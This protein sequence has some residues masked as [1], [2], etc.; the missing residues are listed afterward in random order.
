[1]RAPRAALATTLSRIDGLL[2]DLGR[3]RGDVLDIG[4]LHR[5]TGVPPDVITGLLR[6]EEVAEEP[7]G[8]RVRHRIRHLRDTRR[9]PDG[10]R[11]SYQEIATSFGLSGAAISAI[12]RSSA[13]G[14]PLAATQAGIE[15]YFFGRPNGFLSVEAVPALDA[16]L[17]PVLRRLRLE[18]RS[19]AGRTPA[20]GAAWLS[21]HDD[22][23]GV[24]L[25][26][27]HALPEK[28]W[29]VLNAA[30]T[31]LLEQEQDDEGEDER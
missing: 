10:T 13:Q 3:T 26:R 28:Q 19:A 7:F 6:G 12:V 23:R 14:G 11:P 30:L 20:S 25:R 16:A 5:E 27:A 17:Q 8:D 31:A 9:R 2:L 1:M 22:V 4:G 21:D 15:T 24:A 18:A 29:R